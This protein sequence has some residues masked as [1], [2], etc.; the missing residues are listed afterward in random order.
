M[1]CMGIQTVWLASES[2]S[3]GYCSVIIKCC[4][5]LGD[6]CHYLLKIW[7]ILCI[8]AH[9]LQKDEFGFYWDEVGEGVLTET[10]K[11]NQILHKEQPEN[12]YWELKS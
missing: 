6:I 10:W 3:N 5:S 8:E 2:V 7:Q 11:P 4:T 12:S 1:N 9:A